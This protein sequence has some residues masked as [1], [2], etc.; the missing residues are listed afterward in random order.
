[1]VRQCRAAGTL[2]S[3]AFGVAA[4]LVGFLGGP[5]EAGWA[6]QP[7][8]WAWPMR[9]VVTRLILE[10]FSF[11]ALS[12]NSL[13]PQN[14]RPLACFCPFSRFVCEMTSLQPDSNRRGAGR[15]GGLCLRRTLWTHGSPMETTMWTAPSIG[16]ERAAQPPPS[17]RKENSISPSRAGIACTPISAGKFWCQRQRPGIRQCGCIDTMVR[18]RWGLH[19]SSIT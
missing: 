6:T 8:P 18:F 9:A 1:M 15:A 7:V 14:L 11:Q 13:C 3:R 10:D 2:R 4:H 17:L 5:W 12:G 16:C 19:H